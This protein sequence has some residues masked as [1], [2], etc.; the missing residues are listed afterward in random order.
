MIVE[1]NSLFIES[2]SLTE[3]DATAATA[4]KN[5]LWPSITNPSSY[6]FD[7]ILKY[8]L[9]FFQNKSPHAWNPVVGLSERKTH[10][11]VASIVRSC[12]RG[13]ATAVPVVA[14]RKD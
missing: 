2:D 8:Q 9:A 10:G 1:L 14:A 5:E 3:L 13:P 11:M 4:N 6:Q 12:A 7:P